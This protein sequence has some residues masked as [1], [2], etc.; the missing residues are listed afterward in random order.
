MSGLLS[1]LLAAAGVFAVT[2]VDD[3]IVV[4]TLFSATRT[5]P[6]LS[7]RDVVLG[8]YLGIAT[9]VVLSAIA[10]TGLL[11]LDDHWVGLAG[12]IPIGL[13]VRGLVRATRQDDGA[14]SLRV[15]SALGVAGVTIANGA[16]NI[17]VYGPLFHDAG[18]AGTA[19]YVAVFAVLVGVW[20]VVGR[21]LGGHRVVIAVID[22][23]GR[24][25]V[26]L[27]FVVIG[28]LIVIDAGTVGHLVDR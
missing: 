3:I 1:T 2:N 18:A 20:C 27:V 4:T 15:D 22:S 10:A 5:A 6:M 19:A 28:V 8:Q 17:S 9:L 11:A 25:L 24:W 7:P 13:G 26:P 16:D 21:F 14:P 12:L 23:V